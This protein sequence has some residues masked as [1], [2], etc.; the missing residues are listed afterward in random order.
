MWSTFGFISYI[1][2]IEDSSDSP[3]VLCKSLS[4]MVVNATQSAGVIPGTEIEQIAVLNKAHTMGT[5]RL[6]QHPHRRFDSFIVEDWTIIDTMGS[7]ARRSRAFTKIGSIR[8]KAASFY[9]IVY[10]WCTHRR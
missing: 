9:S 7:K 3:K 6:D 5:R 1:A 8:T 10:S 4:L 2:Q